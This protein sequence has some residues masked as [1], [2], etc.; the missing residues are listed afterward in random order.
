[1]QPMI[2]E[3]CYARDKQSSYREGVSNSFGVDF[4]DIVGLTFI[5]CL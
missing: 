2:T 5:E 3:Y 1:M 4:T